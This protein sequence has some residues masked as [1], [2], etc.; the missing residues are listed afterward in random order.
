[1]LNNQSLASLS[2]G[3]LTGIHTTFDK[4]QLNDPL[5]NVKLLDSDGVKG[6]VADRGPAF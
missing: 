5:E 2:I 6:R 4:K 3:Q 1:M